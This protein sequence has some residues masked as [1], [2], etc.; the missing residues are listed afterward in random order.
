MQV[1]LCEIPLAGAPDILRSEAYFGGTL[2]RLALLDRKRT[3]FCFW[4]DAIITRLES[5][6]HII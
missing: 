1:E 5:F 6:D 2:Q 3:G 4:K